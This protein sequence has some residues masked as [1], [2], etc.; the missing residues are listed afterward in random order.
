M[1]S[2][3]YKKDFLRRIER[4]KDRGFKEK[5]IKQ[6]EKILENPEV[7]KSM[8]YS[9]KGTRELYVHPYRL[10]Y[11]YLKSENKIIFLEIYHK[12]LQ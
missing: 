6:I 4:I 7:G 2:V 1:L 3:D 10:A 11:A 8:R 5:V 12:D 9:R